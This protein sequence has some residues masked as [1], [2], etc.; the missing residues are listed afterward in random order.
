MIKVKNNLKGFII[1][2][3]LKFILLKMGVFTSVLKKTLELYLLPKS[4]PYYEGG[5][6]M[7]GKNV[8]FFFLHRGKGNGDTSVSGLK[9]YN[10]C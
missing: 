9:G 10:T 4:C 6:L 2:I 8:Y 7:P 3:V 1:D 5:G